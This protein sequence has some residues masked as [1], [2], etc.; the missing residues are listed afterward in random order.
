[1]KFEPLPL[2][3]IKNEIKP[4]VKKVRYENIVSSDFIIYIFH[5]LA[6]V[7]LKK[8]IVFKNKLFLSYNI[9]LFT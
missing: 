7:L 6:Y 4:Y 9:Y 2:I 1:M 5:P 8:L 3:N